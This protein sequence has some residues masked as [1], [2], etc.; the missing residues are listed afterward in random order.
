MPIAFVAVD[1]LAMPLRPQVSDA[2]P[3]ALG[4]RA[5]IDTHELAS[6]A[7]RYS[8]DD[9][10]TYFSECFKVKPSALKRYGAFDV[11]LVTDLPLFIDPFLLFNS[12]KRRY[13]ELHEEIVRYLVFLRDK[14]STRELDSTLIDLWYRFPEVR[15]NWFGFTTAGNRG[16]GLGKDFAAALHENLH[17]LFP[18]FGTESVTKG[19]H[20]EK[21]CLIREGVGRDHISDFT[22][23]LLKGYLCTYTQAFAKAHIAPEF[24]R[25][26]AVPR[27]RFKYETEV[28]ESASF[29]LPWHGKDFVLLTPTDLLTKDDTWINKDDLIGGFERIPD[30]I[31]DVALRAQVDNYF[32][33]VLGKHPRRHPTARERADAARRTILE[34]PALIDYYIRYKEEHGAEAE[35]I[36]AARVA[37]SARVY[38]TQIQ[39]LQRALANDGTFYTLPS[40]TYDEAKA[41]LLFLR[42]V[43]E[44]KGGHR[45]FYESGKPI[46]REEDLHIMYRL[47]WFGTPS[48]VSREVN[49]GRGPAD[50]KIARGALDKTIIEFKLAKNTQLE[51]N[52]RRQVEIYQKASDARHALKAIVYF[53]EREFRRVNQIL[54]RLTMTGHPDLVLID[55]R[56]DNKPSASKA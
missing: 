15:Q 34:F 46:Q 9:M 6:H 8:V 21:L 53:S 37:D 36:S 50:F 47:V 32:R 11:S 55:A 48:D 52:L 10:G 29:D 38:V 12:R 28:W 41:R 23:N 39:A 13:Q 49:D 42:D 44:N 17:K 56:A 1:I 45:I 14:A 16:S 27:A 4:A 2:M 30:A 25:R 54:K 51:R 33:K 22:T 19:S 26:V 40:K 18:D 3:C 31:P 7:L 35:G 24:L 43:I 5:Q 20:L